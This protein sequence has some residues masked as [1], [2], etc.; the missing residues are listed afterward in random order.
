M[1]VKIKSV[2][3]EIDDAVG[4]KILLMSRAQFE[5]Y[6]QN[7]QKFITYLEKTG[8]LPEPKPPKTTRNPLRRRKSTKST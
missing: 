7:P 1:D 6:K 8:K 5:I 3:V 2:P 4:D